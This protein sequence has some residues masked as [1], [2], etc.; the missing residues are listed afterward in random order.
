M[1]RSRA[2]IVTIEDLAYAGLGI[3]Q[4]ILAMPLR[5]EPK[6]HQRCKCGRPFELLDNRQGLRCRDCNTRPDRYQISLGKTKGEKQRIFSNRDGIPLSSW[7]LSMVTASQIA[8]EIKNGSFS[9]ENYKKAN[10]LKYYAATL[11]ER[12]ETEKL[13][14]LAPSYRDDYKRMVSREKDYFNTPAATKDI[15]SLQK[16]DV[17]EMMK[18]L[19]SVY[20]LEGKTLKNHMDHFQAFLRYCQVEWDIKFM[21]PAFPAIY[22]QAPLFRWFDNSEQID[23]FQSVEDADKPFVSFLMLSGLRPGEA[24]AVQCKDVDL[25]KRYIS[26]YKTWSGKE[27]RQRRKN[28]KA[29]PFFSP[30]HAELYDW[31]SERVRNNLPDAFL[32]V[33]PR[34]GEPY[35]EGACRRLWDKVREAKKLPKTVRL[36]DFTRHSFASNLLNSGTPLGMISRLLGHADTRTTEKYAH[37]DLNNLRVEAGKI[38]L[39]KSA[40]IIPLKRQ[41]DT[42]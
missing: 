17:K 6:H 29:K 19:Q 26:I 3:T 42:G 12:F 28:K 7:E 5:I 41:G 20:S 25:A 40:D 10:A 1:V 16:S 35:L 2:T 34:T 39:R 11:L 30:I 13:P 22:V 21:M 8:F 31:I 24:R 32:F 27:I 23:I 18:H 33:N 4:G 9:L 14:T 37:C 36:Y 15:R 38:T